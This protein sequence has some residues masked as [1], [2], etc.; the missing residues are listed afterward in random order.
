ML[1]ILGFVLIGLTVLLAAFLLIP[2]HYEVSGDSEASLQIQGSLSWLFGLFKIN[3]TK[4]ARQKRKL[5]IELLGIRKQLNINA[6]NK[7]RK[8]KRAKAKK[9]PRKYKLK[10]SAFLKGDVLKKTFLTLGKIL[11]HCGP[12]YFTVN[13]R[14]G[15]ADPKYTG[16]MCAFLSQFQT[17]LSRYDLTLEPVFDEKVLLGKFSIGGK[18]WLPYLL[19]IILEFLITKPIRNIVFTKKI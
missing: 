12:R 7:K 14:I 8:S 11:K 6:H 16:L 2:Y 4:Y 9:D 15:F 19:V 5:T 10:L 3:F 13:A 18:I 17:Y 1:S